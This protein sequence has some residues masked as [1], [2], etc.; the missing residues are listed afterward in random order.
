MIQNPTARPE[1]HDI[2]G[3][4]SSKYDLFS[5]IEDCPAASKIIS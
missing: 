4:L 2:R 5:T 1:A 3:L